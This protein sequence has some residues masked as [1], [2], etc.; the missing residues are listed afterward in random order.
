MSDS[1]STPS[2]PTGGKELP[3]GTRLEEF[4]IERVLG[5]G[6]FGITYLAR[7]VSLNRP[8]V[9]KE[10]LPGQ[11]A[12]RDTSS[13]VVKPGMGREDQENFRWAMENF[14]KEAALLASLRH[15]GIVSILR[16]FEAFGTAYFVMPFVEGVPFDELIAERKAQGKPFSEEELRGLLERTL[17]ALG[18]LH[19]RGIYHRDI[20]PGN[21]LITNEG[22]PVLIDFGS[23]RQNIGERSMTVIESP[24]YTPFEQ[25]QSRGNIGPWSDLYALAGTLVK[26]ITGHAP[27]KANDRAFDDPFV[28]LAK[29]SELE[30]AYSHSFLRSVDRA[31]AMK[32]AERWQEAE[33]W[34]AA[35]RGEGVPKMVRVTLPQGIQK[36]PVPDEIH[37]RKRNHFPWIIAAAVVLGVFGLAIISSNNE[38]S[39]GSDTV[40]NE[41]A[42]Q[43]ERENTRAAEERAKAAEQRAS[44]MEQEKQELAKRQLD[45]QRAMEAEARQAEAREAKAREEAAAKAKIE[46]SSSPG[47]KAGEEQDFEIAPGTKITMCWIPPGEFLMG[48]PASEEGRDDDETQHR[49]T[50][51]KGFWLAK[52]ETTQAQWQAVMGGN[53]SYLR[54]DA[55]PVENLSWNDIAGSGGFIEKVNRSMPTEGWRFSLPTEAQW[56]YACR[57]GTSLTYAVDLEQMAWYANNSDKRT[58]PVGKK[59]ANAWGLHDM[60]GNLWEWCMDRH[61][62]YPSGAVTDPQGAAS[63]TNRLLRGG[64]WH[65]SELYCRADYRYY[66]GGTLDLSGFRVAFI[67]VP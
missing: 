29:R 67:S 12:H 57:A 10:N 39:P 26:A 21:I 55:L 49:V 56:E 22:D 5:V 24:G 43:I 11:F 61:G 64:S 44:E 48:S 23:A 63:G 60:H 54:G 4:L 46:Q 41:A 51:S 36:P 42:I 50:I 16:S 19:E 15:P 33:E 17:S 62:D 45:K 35:L 6:G 38:T 40:A 28:P 13:L 66:A 58:H 2:L 31:L 25:L 20:K 9:I 27:P 32:P 47:S 65:D 14:S 8:V 7:D 18:Y 37:V 52:T 30:G 1:T 59:K 34:L 53:P 3:P